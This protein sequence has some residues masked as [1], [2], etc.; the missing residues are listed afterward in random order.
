M[1][2]SVFDNNTKFYNGKSI[3]LRCNINKAAITI[4]TKITALQH[5][6]CTLFGIITSGITVN[7]IWIISYVTFCYILIIYLGKEHSIFKMISP[8]LE[9]PAI[10]VAEDYPPGEIT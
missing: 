7:F 5:F 2:N 1:L 9:Y 8:T 10:V 3:L 6:C 4:H